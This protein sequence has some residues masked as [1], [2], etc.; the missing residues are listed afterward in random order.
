MPYSLTQP[1][2]SDPASFV[3]FR[4]VLTPAECNELIGLSKLIPK[5]SAL[6]A[7]SKEKRISDVYWIHWQAGIDGLFAKLANAVITANNKTWDFHLGGFME[8]LQLTHYRAENSGHYDWHEDHSNVGICM[9]RKIS[10]TLVLN[11]DFEG[12]EFELFDTKPIENLTQGSL[13]LFPSF[14]VHRVLPIAKG[15]RWSL[16]FWVT[17]PPFV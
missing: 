9:N 7:S 1:L 5:E 10:G 16:V 15:E 3:L 6:T 11:N 4:N 17:G 14:K 8:P 13:I 2:K 12:G